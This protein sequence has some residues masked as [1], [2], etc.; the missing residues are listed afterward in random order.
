[1]SH[2]SVST[3]ASS[4][5]IRVARASLD[6]RGIG[7]SRRGRGRAATALSDQRDADVRRMVIAVL[8]PWYSPVEWDSP[9][10]LGGIGSGKKRRPARAAFEKFGG[11]E[12]GFFEAPVECMRPLAM[13]F[14][15]PRTGA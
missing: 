7:A 4:G 13:P 2:R 9:V 6:R 11:C 5:G 10:E 1:M 3:H 8:S 12:E 14:R 15:R